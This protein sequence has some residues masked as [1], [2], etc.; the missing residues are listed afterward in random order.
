MKGRGRMHWTFSGRSV[1]GSRS[2]CVL[3]E[4]TGGPRQVAIQ[5]LL[6]Y[7]WR[8]LVL[9]LS[10]GT[11]FDVVPH[12]GPLTH[13]TWIITPS[14][15]WLSGGI[16]FRCIEGLTIEGVSIE[17]V[18][19]EWRSR[20]GRTATVILVFFNCACLKGLLWLI[21]RGMYRTSLLAF[22]MC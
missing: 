2:G 20:C 7:N 16:N 6:Q 11:D 12:E 21:L 15:I 19:I 4:A 9:L 18:S 10:G 1:M 8:Q 17:G 5:W 3:C 13:P 22:W 14:T